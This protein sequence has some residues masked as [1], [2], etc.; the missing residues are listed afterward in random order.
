MRI[1]DWSSDVCSSDLHQIEPDGG[2][3]RIGK[4]IQ[5]DRGSLVEDQS[6]FRAFKFDFTADDQSVGDARKQFK[7]LFSVAAKIPQPFDL[8]LAG[9]R[10]PLDQR[11]LCMREVKEAKRKVVLAGKSGSGSVK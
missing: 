10:L 3:L 11:F 7:P 6:V 1:S 9:T 5:K 2:H 4:T 8:L